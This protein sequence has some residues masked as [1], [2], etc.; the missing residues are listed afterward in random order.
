MWIPTNTKHRSSLLHNQKY[1]GGFFLK[2][3]NRVI[4][5]TNQISV[6]EGRWQWQV[7]HTL[8]DCTAH[9]TVTSQTQCLTLVQFSFAGICLFVC[10]SFLFFFNFCDKVSSLAPDG[11]YLTMQT[12]QALK[13]QRSAGL[14]LLTAGNIGGHYH[15]QLSFV[16]FKGSLSVAKAGLQLTTQDKF[17]LNSQQFSCF[18]LLSSGITRN[19]PPRSA[20]FTS[21]QCLGDAGLRTTLWRSIKH[22][23]PV[24]QATLVTGGN[25]H[26]N[27]D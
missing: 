11:L 22:I 18:H 8:C 12:R 9:P 14:C 4:P 3:K 5:N 25:F 26:F 27:S 6:T 24:Q 17:A 1:F 16:L 10:F 23:C 2:P 20:V 15:A 19:E 21:K 13:A 7:C